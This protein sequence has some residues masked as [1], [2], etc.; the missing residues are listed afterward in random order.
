MKLLF[1]QRFLSLLD[2]YDIYNEYDEV[3]YTVESKLSFSHYMNIYQD[4]RLV[5]TLQQKVF[6]FLPKFDLYIHDEYYDRIVKEFTFFHPYFH[7]EESGWTV[8]GD[9]TAWDYQIFDQ[10]HNCIATLSKE[11]FHLTD[12][13]VMD[14]FDDK[15]ALQV[16]LIVLAIDAEK[17]TNNN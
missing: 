8:E 13:Y 11:L 16:L 1:R 4:D 10:N 3:E 5:A 2:S 6:T 12:T 14:I 7:L 15:Y 17:C 9:F